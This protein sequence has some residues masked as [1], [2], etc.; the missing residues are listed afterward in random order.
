MGVKG[1]A[2]LLALVALSIIGEIYFTDVFKVTWVSISL[3]FFVLLG[4]YHLFSHKFNK[5]FKKK[6]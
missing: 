5:P 3:V 6:D 2:I 4:L 1:T